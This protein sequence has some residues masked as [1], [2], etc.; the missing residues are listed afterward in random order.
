MGLSTLNMSYTWDHGARDLLCLAP[1]I[2]YHVFWVH[3]RWSTYGYFVH[4]TAEW[5]STVCIDRNWFIQS[6]NNEHFG[7]CYLFTIVNT[8]T[9]YN[10]YMW[11][12]WS[13]SFPSFC[14]CTRQWN[15]WVVINF[16]R[17]WIPQWLQHCNSYQQCI[18]FQCLHILTIFHFTDHGHPTTFHPITFN[19][20]CEVAPHSVFF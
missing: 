3:P 10:I 12:C 11:I 4:L 18:E 8:N 2:K 13:T 1:F 20:K 15:S 6:P 5:Y 17:K 14:V 16:L 7:C 19:S 9:M